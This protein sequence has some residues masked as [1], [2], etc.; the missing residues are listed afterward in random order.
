MSRHPWKQI[1]SEY[2]ISGLTKGK[3]FQYN[4]ARPEAKLCRTT[5]FNK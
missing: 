2:H 1:I 5:F 4:Q 3:F